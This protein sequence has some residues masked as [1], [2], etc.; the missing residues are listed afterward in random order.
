MTQVIEDMVSRG[1]RCIGLAF[2]DYP[3]IAFKTDEDET[4][5]DPDMSSGF[6]LVAIVALKDPLR[7]DV[8]KSVQQCQQSGIIVR[9]VTGDHPKTAEFIAAECGIRPID[10]KDLLIIT[11]DE[12]REMDP[13]KLAECLPNIRIMAR[14]TPQDKE[15]LVNMY[16]KQKHVFKC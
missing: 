13:Q 12:F 2:K 3:S 16:M 10:R 6:V 15:R 11:G 9:M 5:E 1:L 8:L 14:S 4:A 7:P